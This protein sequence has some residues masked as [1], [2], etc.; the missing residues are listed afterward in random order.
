LSFSN[1]GILPVHVY[2]IHEP[3]NPPVEGRKHAES[4]VF[5][6]DGFSLMAALLPPAW[7]AIKGLWLSLAIYLAFFAGLGSFLSLIGV[8]G[9]WVMLASTTINLVIGFEASEIQRWSLDLR[10]WREIATVSGPNRETCERRF[11]DDWLS[12]QTP[13]VHSQLVQ[14]AAEV[15]TLMPASLEDRFKE[16]LDHIRGRLGLRAG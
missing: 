9:D 7:F 13:R 2:T 3:P 4:M 5:V 16:C 10:N 6:R 12:E 1:F 8:Q 11:F 14:P 15:R